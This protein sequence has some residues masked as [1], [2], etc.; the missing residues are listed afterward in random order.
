MTTTLAEFES[1][2]QLDHLTIATTNNWTWSLRPQQPTL[3]A[4]VISLRSFA[5]R[6]SDIPEGA[7]EDLT[8]I[9]QIVERTLSDCFA[10][11]KINHLMLMMVDAHV[12][13][14]V[15]PRYAQER[16]FA[17]RT[18]TDEGWPKFPVLANDIADKDP[19]LL[20]ELVQHL[21]EAA[22]VH[23]GSST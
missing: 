8:R 18:W 20:A 14:H 6:F 2:F 10:Y 15:I 22:T 5:S 3:G 1:A 19:E 9:I 23:L 16:T 12:H 7:G 21:R 4:G 11:D 17:G 13:M